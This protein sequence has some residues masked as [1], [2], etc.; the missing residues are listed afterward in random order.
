[1]IGTVRLVLG[2]LA[3]ACTTAVLGPIQMLA[4]HA[5]WPREDWPRKL[6]HRCNLAILG[7]RVHRVG[8]MSEKRPLLIASNH[9]SWADIEIIG[10]FDDISFVAR[11]DV[12]GW[13]LVGWLSRMQRTIYVDR[14][15]RGKA[16]KQANE[17]ALRLAQGVPIVLFPEGTT[18]DGN[19]IL[20]FKS[21]LFGAAQM[22]V[23]DGGLDRVHVQPVAL[24]YTRTHGIAMGRQFRPKV[25]WIGDTDL[26]PHL[27]PVLKEGA[28]DIELHYGEP[29]EFAAG[30][31]RKALAREME[32][33]VAGMMAA[34]LRD[35]RPN[36]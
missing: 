13:P 8:K 26:A 29:V 7:F 2:L 35:P 3:V 16:G 20:P 34:A 15:R 19:M 12:E 5:G 32:Q 30:G 11:A 9:V 28:I 31:D 33:R 36:R 23:A 6:W 17:I 1:M 14:N 22:A 27:V 18:G 24:V 21:T 25:S 10:A 4:V